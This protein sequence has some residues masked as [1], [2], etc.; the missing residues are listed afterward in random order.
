MNEN[1][2]AFV[3]PVFYSDK[4]KTFDSYFVDKIEGREKI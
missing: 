4:K 2:G 3:T 1:S